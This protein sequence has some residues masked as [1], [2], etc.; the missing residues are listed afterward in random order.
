MTTYRR[1]PGD[2]WLVKADGA[3]LKGEKMY[4]PEYHVG[5]ETHLPNTVID[6]VIIGSWFHLEQMDSR[7]Y[8]MNVGG[9]MINIRLTKDGKPKQVTVEVGERHEGCEYNL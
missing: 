7:S 9:V 5:S 2:T 4:G 8:W 1:E 3:R 6:E